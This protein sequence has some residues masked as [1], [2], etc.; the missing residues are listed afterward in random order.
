MKLTKIAAIALDGS[1]LKWS[2]I[3]KDPKAVDLGKK[4]CPLCIKFINDR[5]IDCPVAK[6]AGAT[7]CKNTPYID[8]VEHTTDAHFQYSPR[9]RVPGCKICMKSAKAVVA[10][11]ESLKP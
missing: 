4:N 10:F 6:K 1:T 2:R 11:L 7:F 8:W 3:V 9:H 5:C